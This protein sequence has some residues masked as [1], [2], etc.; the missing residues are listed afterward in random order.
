MVFGVVVAGVASTLW[1]E[2]EL[3]MVV[4]ALR[5][6]DPVCALGN[7]FLK[8][9]GTVTGAPSFSVRVPFNLGIIIRGG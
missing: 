2:P 3:N 7:V 6:L 8:S 4:L 1:R 5:E 9:L